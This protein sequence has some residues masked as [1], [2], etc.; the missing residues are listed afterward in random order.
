MCCKI[1]NDCMVLLSPD[2]T[3]WDV[4]VWYIQTFITKLAMENANYIITYW[5]ILL[6]HVADSVFSRTNQL[7]AALVL[8]DYRK[9]N[10]F[11]RSHW[12]IMYC[13]A[14]NLQ[15][16]NLA[17][18]I[19]PV[20]FRWHSYIGWTP[21]WT[22]LN[23]Q[24]TCSAITCGSEVT[25]QLFKFNKQANK[26]WPVTSGVCSAHTD[27]GCCCTIESCTKSPHKLFS[28]RRNKKLFIVTLS[29]LNFATTHD[30]TENGWII[31]IYI[32]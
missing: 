8:S 16:E 9:I 5:T 29:F 20:R 13:V 24:I 32:H 27:Q 1:H 4:H 25:C 15:L 21:M 7:L 26:I 19:L 11:S 30:Y 10:Y 12:Y 3:N 23:Y 14:F 22:E 28:S 18:E 31:T 17:S 6:Y 2:V